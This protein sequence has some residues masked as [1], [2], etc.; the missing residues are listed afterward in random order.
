MPL[1]PPEDFKC[2]CHATSQPR[3]LSRRKSLSID[4]W[5]GFGYSEILARC[6]AW[7]LC[8][9]TRTRLVDGLN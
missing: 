3:L 5:A 7:S 1:L 8:V 2:N 4:S 6:C 9:L